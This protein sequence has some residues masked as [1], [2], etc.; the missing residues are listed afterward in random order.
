MLKL[1]RRASY[2]ECLGCSPTDTPIDE[3]ALRRLHIAHLKRVPFENL[4]IH[5]GRPIVLDEDRIVDK[6]VGGRGGTCYELNGA[7]AALLASLDVRV[8]R[9]EARV[10]GGATPSVPFDHLCLLVHLDQR[11]LVDVG[12][13]ACFAHPVPLVVEEPHVDPNGTFVVRPWA[14]DDRWLELVKDGSHAYRFTLTPLPLSAFEPG[15]HH[16]QTS[17]R[18]HFTHNPVCS[19]RT[20][21]G[22]RVTLRGRR[23]IETAP[24]GTRTETELNVD[25]ARA[26]LAS[27]FGIELPTYPG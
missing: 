23:L 12:F 19:R 21:A 20:A 13:G 17:P 11:W 1:E 7:F 25:A 14:G 6:L 22:G 2:L 10:E 8:D 4:D 9:L 26:A 18:S 24:D 15:N 16:H 27:H 3:S 5:L